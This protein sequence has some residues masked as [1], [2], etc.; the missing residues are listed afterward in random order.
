[1]RYLPVVLSLFLFPSAVPAETKLTPRPLDSI[2]AQTYASA[3]DGSA[4]VRSLV[5]RLE[6]S[7]VIVHIVTV[8]QMPAGIG[9]MTRFV[10]SRGGYRYV[11]ISL[12]SDL[13]PRVRA[14]ILG[15]E[16]QHAV[17]VAES[18]AMDAESI[19][20]LFEH[21]GHR[22]GQFFE[23]MAAIRTE[24]SVRRELGARHVLQ[25]E[26]VVKFDH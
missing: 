10:T 8:P 20:E 11:R 3:V 6:S 12:G 18:A 22:I 17:E 23:T 24:R 2:S 25:A 26:P 19:R 15:H 16:L 5:E 7:N 1:M 21:E 14:V 9:G 13:A 4:K